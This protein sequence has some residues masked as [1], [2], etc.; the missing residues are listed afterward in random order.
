[1]AGRRRTNAQGGD[2]PSTQRATRPSNRRLALAGKWAT[3]QGV[4]G[5]LL[6]AAKYAAN[7]LAAHR[8]HLAPTEVARLDREAEQLAAALIRLGD[9]ALGVTDTQRGHAA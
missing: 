7:G 3:A 1:M 5:R 9:R 8:G 4:R 6:V 2:L